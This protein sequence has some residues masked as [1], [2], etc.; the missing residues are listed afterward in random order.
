MLKKLESIVYNKVKDRPAVKDALK[1]I[2]QGFFSYFGMRRQ[3]GID[4]LTV[5]ERSYFGFH[6]KSPWSWDNELLLSHQFTGRGN[7]VESAKRSMQI[8]IFRGENWLEPVPITET[9]AWN[10]QQGAQLQWV[11]QK[12]R[13][14]FNDFLKGRCVAREVDINGNEQ[15]V[16]EYPVAAVS[17]DGHTFASICFDAF[18]YEMPGYGYDFKGSHVRS[19]VPR[20]ELIVFDKKSVEKIIAGRAIPRLSQMKIDNERSFISHVAFSE[21]GVKIA[22]LRRNK[23]PGRRLLSALYILD[24]KSGEVK[25][26]PFLDMVSHYCWISDRHILAYGNDEKGQGFFVADVESITLEAVSKELGTEDGHPHSDRLGRRILVDSYPDKF[27]LQRLS[28]WDFN[29]KGRLD[30]A[31]LFSPMRFWGRYR[32]DLH[33]RVRADGAYAC[34][35]C[36]IN[37]VRSLATVPLG[38]I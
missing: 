18:G 1:F 29:N 6:D 26:M 25:R 37:G 27:R 34:I 28:V 32:V 13:I 3:Y 2:Y 24:R 10:W 8:T 14:L 31:Q 12:K 15:F 21:G 22:F 30:V 11:G 35:D 5:R 20:D 4:R 36:S 7:E 33:P 9:R 17:R 19:T 38:R 23:K 16:H